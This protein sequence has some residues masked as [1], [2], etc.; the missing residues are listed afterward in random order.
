MISVGSRK[1]GDIGE[2][3]GRPSPLGNPFRPSE[4]GVGETLNKYEVWLKDRI[5]VWDTKVTDELRR[6]EEIA[7]EGDL[8]LVCF[9]APNPCH[10]DVIK[11]AI[12]EKW[13]YRCYLGHGIHQ[14]RQC[15][16]CPNDC[17]VHCDDVGSGWLCNPCCSKAGDAPPVDDQ[18]DEELGF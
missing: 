4:Q 6:L 13:I 14:R 18:Y 3:V 11:R 9:C 12:E 10:A 7:K 8:V 2:Y 16:C 17:C 1:R 5:A 15:S